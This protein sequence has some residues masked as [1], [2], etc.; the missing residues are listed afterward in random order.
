MWYCDNMK[1]ASIY[2][3]F[4][5][6]IFWKAC[7]ISRVSLSGMI[8]QIPVFLYSIDM[9]HKSPDLTGEVDVIAHAA[10]RIWLFSLF[11]DMI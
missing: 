9:A 8:S 11:C 4:N 5:S 2:G 6:S 10:V 1:D 3:I 7:R